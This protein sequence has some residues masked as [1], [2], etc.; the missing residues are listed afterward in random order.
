M[1]KNPSAGDKDMKKAIFF[2][3]TK[4]ESRW[5]LDIGRQT[6]G[7]NKTYPMFG[8]SYLKSDAD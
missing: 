4:E 7:K 8:Y 5:F 3:K 6:N 1:E 2:L